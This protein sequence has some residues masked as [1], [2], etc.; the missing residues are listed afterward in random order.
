MASELSEERIRIIVR[1]EISKLVDDLC[2]KAVLPESLQAEE[3]VDALAAAVKEIA[4]DSAQERVE[5]HEQYHNH[6]AN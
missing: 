2:Q 1:E 4:K 3:M 5:Q 6:E